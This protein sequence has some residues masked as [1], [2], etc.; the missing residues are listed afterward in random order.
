MKMYGKLQSNV[1]KMKKI[2]QLL[3]FLPHGPL[4]LREQGTF[5]C[6]E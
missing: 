4:S 3:T 1:G 5:C 2:P 6:D